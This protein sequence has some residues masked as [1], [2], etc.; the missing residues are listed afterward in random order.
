[1]TEAAILVTMTNLQRALLM[2][3]RAQG[4]IVA[5]ASPSFYKQLVARHK[6]TFKVRALI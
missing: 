2:M 6:L 1:M 3:L 5:S 4:L